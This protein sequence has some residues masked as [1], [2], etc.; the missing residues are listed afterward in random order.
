MDALY[1]KQNETKEVSEAGLSLNSKNINEIKTMK[2]ELKKGIELINIWREDTEHEEQS[3]EQQI[4]LFMFDNYIALKNCELEQF[5]IDKL[6]TIYPNWVE[7]V[8]NEII[9][10]FK[11]T[12]NGV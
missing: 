5:K 10:T 4:W 9:N 3:K 6:N 8:E 12:I 1:E 11:N 2:D 7:Y